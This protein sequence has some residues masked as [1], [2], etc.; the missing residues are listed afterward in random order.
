MKKNL[1]ILAA[2]LL[3]TAAVADDFAN[4]FDA[5]EAKPRKSRPPV[6][7]WWTMPNCIS[8]RMM[9]CV[10]RSAAKQ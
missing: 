8:A 3:C 6:L 5:V 2:V 1:M 9:N 7:N 10:T 4:D